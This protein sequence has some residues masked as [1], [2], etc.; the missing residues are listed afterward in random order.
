MLSW[1]TALVVPES[2]QGSKRTAT[3]I[4]RRKIE[5][6]PGPRGAELRHIRHALRRLAWSSTRC[7]VGLH[8]LT[9][10][11]CDHTETHTS[12]RAQRPNLP[13]FHL[14]I[15]HS[16]CACTFRQANVRSCV[17]KLRARTRVAGQI[18]QD[19]IR[20]VGI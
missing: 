13:I 11:A 2:T 3:C 6:A 16:V 18:A 9:D 19:A 12:L 1:P 5:F 20:R 4:S 14:P 15:L 10:L 17:A 8:S 7:T